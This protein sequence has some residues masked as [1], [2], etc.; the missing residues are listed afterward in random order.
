MTMAAMPGF[1]KFLRRLFQA[2]HAPFTQRIGW[3]LLLVVMLLGVYWSQLLSG[4]RAQQQ[5]LEQ[6]T[7]L[8]AGQMAKSMAVQVDT[9]FSGLDFATQNL[10]AQYLEPDA[11]GFALAV[12]TALQAYPKGSILQIAVADRQGRVVYSSLQPASSRKPLPSIQDREHFRVHA[13]NGQS[14]LYISHPLLGRVSG[15]W[16][17]Q[18]SRAMRVGDQFAG[19]VVVSV[20]PAYLSGFF[21]DILD[22]PRDVILLLRD[23]GAYLARSRDEAAVLGTSDLPQREFLRDPAKTRGAY[24]TVATVDGV[25]RYYAWNRVGPFP[26]LVSVGLD[27]AAALEPLAPAVRASLLR[28]GLSSALILAGAIA[29]AWLT[30]QKHRTQALLEAGEERLRK[31]VAQ[32][33]GALFQFRVQPDGS[34]LFPYMSPGIYGLHRV[35]AA[36]VGLNGKAALQLLHPQ[37][38]QRVRDEVRAATAQ[39]TTWDSQYRVRLTDGTVRWLHGSANPEREPDG[40]V[41]WHG[42]IHD[43]TQERTIQEALHASEERLR[44]TMRATH[45][46]LWEWD[47]VTHRIQW[48]RRCCEMLGYTD[49]TMALDEDTVRRWIHPSDQ[50][51]YQRHLS[52]HLQNGEDYRCEFRLQTTTGGWLW[53]ESRGDVT[54]TVEGRPVRM[55]GTHTDISQRVAQTQLRRALLDESAAA[56]ILTTPQRSIS[57][58]NA[59]AVELFGIAGTTLAGQSFRMLHKDEAQFQAFGAFYPALRARGSI[60]QEWELR[61]GDGATR[62]FDMHGTLLDPQDPDGPVIWTIFDTDDRHRAEAALSVAQQRLTAIIARFPGGVLIQDRASGCVIAINQTLC[63]L[64][65][66]TQS[67]QSLVGQP[68]E[69]LTGILTAEAVDTLFSL[70]PPADLFATDAAQSVEHSFPDGR[71]FEIHRVPLAQG[72]DNLGLLWLVHE[73]TDRKRRESTL[74]RLA[75]TD[76]LTGLPNR[77]SFMARL[78]GELEAIRQEGR[79][80]GVVVMLDIDF[81]K[82]V[83]DTWGHAIG[84]R[85]LKHLARLLLGS[86]RLDDMAGRLGGEEFALLLPA[87]SLE[88]GLALAERLRETVALQDV[89]TGTDS[90]TFTISLGVSVLEA[91]V[92]G[93]GESL[94]RA[95]AAMYHSKRNGR[96]RVTAWQAGMTGGPAPVTR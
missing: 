27:K 28:N 74:E 21:Q 41:L 58:A 48:D 18:F 76:P 45:D 91:D 5:D 88:G 64:L 92:S 51:R 68:Q 62:W 50:D 33:P 49:A 12:Q 46:G 96:N 75:T 11:S 26:V 73:I 39:L 82:K 17:I 23:D 83:N 10:V 34:S 57:M 66:L 90:I 29:I 31:L 80:S 95:D 65:Q 56:I 4:H 32:I 69:A 37:D 81:F 22:Q 8:R 6:Q 36:E 42:Y 94:A 25:E 77:R 54:D 72:S 1:W 30:W 59:R 61:V 86:L 78:T 84:D 9:L 13:H 7:R 60:R 24:E 89:P 3:G 87:T 40:S 15:Q 85:V 44:L 35:S 55:M 14:G 67:P 19:V 16:A 79:P 53:V 47:L 63:D 43:V 70:R 20:S 38:A 2:L 93:I 52:A 71:A